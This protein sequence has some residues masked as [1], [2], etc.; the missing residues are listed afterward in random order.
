MIQYS[1][2]R[3]AIQ[4]GSLASTATFIYGV[5]VA[6]PGKRRTP[7]LLGLLGSTVCLCLTAAANL[8]EKNL[9]RNPEV[10]NGHFLTGGAASALASADDVPY[11]RSLMGVP[12]HQPPRRR[13]VGGPDGHRLR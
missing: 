1:K 4:V 6:K 9:V 12:Q 3:T 2:H 7:I 8:E 5:A 11:L 13:R 10:M